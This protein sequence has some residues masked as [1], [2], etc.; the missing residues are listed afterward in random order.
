MDHIDALSPLL[1]EDDL[2]VSGKELILNTH[3]C[4]PC[5]DSQLSVTA[6]FTNKTTY[7]ETGPN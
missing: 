7:F 3:H 2:C 5:C 1:P 4:N 6:S